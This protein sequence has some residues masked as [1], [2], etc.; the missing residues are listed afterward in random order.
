MAAGREDLRDERLLNK[1]ALRATMLN[2]HITMPTEGLVHQHMRQDLQQCANV[3]ATPQ[4]HEAEHVQEAHEP[5]P[6]TRA[7]AAGLPPMGGA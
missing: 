6:Q 1:R 5:H 3:A 2:K 7:S 4:R